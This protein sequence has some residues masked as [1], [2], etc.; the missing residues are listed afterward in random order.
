MQRIDFDFHC[1]LALILAFILIPIARCQS[2]S[3]IHVKSF[4]GLTVADKVSAAQQTCPAAPVPCILVIDASLNAAAPGTMPA[5]CSNCSL[6]DFRGGPPASKSLTGAVSVADSPY[7][8]CTGN[9]NV[10][11]SVA[12]NNAISYVSGLGG[13]EVYFPSGSKCN[14]KNPIYLT[15]GVILRAPVNQYSVTITAQANM[16]AMITQSSFSS[17]IQ[18]AAIIGLRLDGNKGAYTIPNLISISPVGGIFR[19]DTVQDGS[20]NCLD[21]IEPQNGIAWTNQVQGG[22]YG[23]CNGYGI[24]TTMTDSVIEHAYVSNNTLG[25]MFVGGSGSLTIT[26]NQ[27]EK[28]TSAAGITISQ[29]PAVCASPGPPFMISGNRFELNQ[30]D[31]SI[32]NTTGTTTCLYLPISVVN[33]EYYSTTGTN[34]SV[35][36]TVI[37]GSVHD[38]FTGGSPIQNMAWNT[39]TSTGWVIS[40]ST[41][42]APSAVF[43]GLPPDA[44]VTVSGPAGAVGYMQNS[45]FSSSNTISPL[46][47]EN[48]GSTGSELRHFA[49][50]PAGSYNNGVQ[51]GDDAMIYDVLGANLTG[52]LFI[53]PRSSSLA[54]N[55]TRWDSNGNLNQ[56][57]NVNVSGMLSLGAVYSNGTCTTALTINPQ[58]GNDQ[59]VTLTAADTCALTFTP[60]SSGMYTLNLELIQPAS[61]TGQVSGGQWPSGTGFAATAP[62][63]ATSNGGVAFATCKVPASGNTYCILSQ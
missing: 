16:P 44:Q 35:S 33:N 9:V 43:S 4:P 12:I 18:D 11:D 47:T 62:T 26:D 55:G 20:G 19:D 46:I 5:L 21:L 7:G 24:Y 6:W 32:I 53:G 14:I 36:G 61:G 15:S 42:L 50:L 38:N 58:N 23:G 29:T 28:E 63:L 27:I 13:G 37:G 2:D 48:N 10:D 17:F 1:V 40:V 54:G 8:A 49:D 52:G 25:G 39:A 56:Y 57:G 45:N 31:V 30:T 41:L 34:I 59:S 60:P 22:T 3:M 51:T